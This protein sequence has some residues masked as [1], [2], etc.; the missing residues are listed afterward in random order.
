MNECDFEV[1]QDG[2]TVARGTGPH[3]AAVAEATHYAMMY[4]Q[5]GPV[6][7]TVHAVSRDWAGKRRRRQVLKGSLQGVSIEAK[8]P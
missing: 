1:K 6:S 5:D 2:A 8:L 3:D 7:W 4:G